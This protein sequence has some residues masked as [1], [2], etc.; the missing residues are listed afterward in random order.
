MHGT[1]AS[2][3]MRAQSANALEMSVSYA[4]KRLKTDA[5]D[6]E[7]LN[8]LVLSLLKK[9]SVGGE[10]SGTPR[11]SQAHRCGQ[12]LPAENSM[13]LPSSLEKPR[14]QA[15][16]EPDESPLNSPSPSVRQRHL[17]SSPRA[18]RH[19]EK[20]TFGQLGEAS[21]TQQLL[22]LLAAGVG[23]PEVVHADEAEADSDV[24][25]NCRPVRLPPRRAT[26][27]AFVSPRR[28]LHLDRAYMR[29]L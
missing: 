4:R 6:E 5:P 21:A 11:R 14:H 7:V 15:D 27:V 19:E 23:R 9:P 13:S 10:N 24:D 18:T 17:S 16:R 29:V 2:S 12:E 8:Q 1:A 3:T 20:R 28:P 26:P 22:A 25:D